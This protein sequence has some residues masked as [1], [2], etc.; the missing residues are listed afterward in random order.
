MYIYK[1][2]IIYKDCIPSEHRGIDYFLI[3]PIVSADK[4]NIQT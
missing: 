1:D 4:E 2:M 3:D